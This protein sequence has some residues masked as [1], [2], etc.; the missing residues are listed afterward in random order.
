MAI[1]EFIEDEIASSF[2]Q[3]LV[4]LTSRR[5]LYQQKNGESVD[6]PF[7]F[8]SCNLKT[9]S[10]YIYAGNARSAVFVCRQDSRFFPV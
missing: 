1:S 2:P 3:A 10:N 5:L 4:I 7:H 6:S 9:V 8:T